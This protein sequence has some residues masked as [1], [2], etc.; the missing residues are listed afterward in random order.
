MSHL[1]LL[2]GAG[3]LAGAMNA[4]AGGGSFV[5]LPA[6]IAAGLPSV[7]ANASNTVALVPGGLASAWAYRGPALRVCGVPLRQ[8]VVVTLAGGLAG[9]LLL[10]ATPSQDFD[11]ILP[12]LLLLATLAI[13]FGPRLGAAL[14]RRTHIGWLPVLLVQF[15]LGIYGGYFGGAVGLM[16][17]AAWGLLGETDIRALNMPRTLLVTLANVIASV[18]FVFAGAVRWPQM[19][20]VLVGGLAGGYLGA[21]LGRVVPRS[22]ARVGT[23]VWTVGMTLAFFYRAGR[24]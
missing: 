18:V 23:L 15:G 17:L 19:A 2:C 1:L 21:R 13:A 5:T 7:Q 3:L 6:L 14:Q 20:A 11:R 8:L 4:L 22:A 9:S 16:M 24:L 10:L 12:W